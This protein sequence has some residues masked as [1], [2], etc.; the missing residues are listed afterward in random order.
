MNNVYLINKPEGLT[1]FDVVRKV[2]GVLKE[3]RIGHTGTLDP[4]ATGLLIICTGRFTRLADYFHRY[5]KT[6][7]A[8]FVL[9]AF[10][11]TDDVTG[12]VLK[13][14]D[15][16][17]LTSE[18]LIS[19]LNGFKGEIEQ[20]PPLI[21]AKKINGNRLYKLN[22]N[23]V[24]VKAK[25]TKVL[26]QDIN[27]LAFNPPEFEVEITCGTGT[28]IRSIARDTGEK[29]GCGCYVKG[30]KR[31]SIGPYSVENAFLPESAKPIS[32]LDILPDLEAF[33]LQ[34]RDLKR[35]MMGNEVLI[36]GIECTGG[37]V[38]VF[39]PYFKELVS[40][41]RCVNNK[42]GVKLKPLK[43]FKGEL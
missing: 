28:Y 26:V 23:G 29:L 3:K 14:F 39:T 33:V 27:L 11:D 37:V 40:I 25:S 8:I 41:C 10:T 13:K 34:E 38:R 18:S 12:R 4:F 15:I 30:L 16:P 36:K 6:Y 19:V 17:L 2:K 9:G 32:H 20:I 21:S 31:L 42:D 7:R 24:Q 1:S 43:V 5:L 35:I 22:R